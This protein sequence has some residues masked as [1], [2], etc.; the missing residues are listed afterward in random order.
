MEDLNARAYA[1]LDLLLTV[2]YVAGAIG[3]LLS[4]ILIIRC[5]PKGPRR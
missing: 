4:L 1:L 5:S 2:I 3:I